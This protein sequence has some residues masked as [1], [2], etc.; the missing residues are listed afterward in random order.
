MEEPGPD[1][2]EGQILAHVGLARLRPS[3][4]TALDREDRHGGRPDGEAISAGRE[5][6]RE[7]ESGLRRHG[8]ELAAGAGVPEAADRVVA[9]GGE[10]PA[11][12]AEGKVPDAAIGRLEDP[13]A[14]RIGSGDPRW[15]L[16]AS[17]RR[18][19]RV[20]QDE[21]RSHKHKYP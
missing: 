11:V 20:H 7:T 9:R 8:G 19:A 18:R 21:N 2:I 14:A 16:L 10:I 15:R 6:H 12:G 13:G 17:R 1:G 5:C 4:T 3:F